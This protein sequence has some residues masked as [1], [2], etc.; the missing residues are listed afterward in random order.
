[1]GGQDKAVIAWLYCLCSNCGGHLSCCDF[2]CQVCCIG[3]VCSVSA[4]QL[5]KHISGIMP[6]SG[7]I[8]LFSNACILLMC[9]AVALLCGVVG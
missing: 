7:D 3:S 6:F 1:M 9:R 2:Y 8:A 5:R 4:L